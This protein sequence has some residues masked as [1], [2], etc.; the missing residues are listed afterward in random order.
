[1][2][3]IAV[4]VVGSN[5]VGGMLSSGAQQSAA[6]TAANAQTQSAQ[7]GIQEQQRQFNQIQAML[8]PFV[9]AATGVAPGGVS[10]PGASPSMGVPGAGATGQTYDQIRASLLPQYTTTDYSNPQWSNGEVQTFQGYGQKVDEAG[11]NAAI[12]QVMQQQGQSQPGAPGS[13]AGGASGG[14]QIGGSLGAQMALAGVNGP[15]AQQAMVDQIKSMPAFQSQLTLG[16]NRILQNAAATGGL[17]GGNT[18]AA[19]AYFAPSLLAQQINNQYAMLGGLTSIGQNAAAMVGNAG[20]TT[21]QNIAGLYGQQ[22]SAAAGAAIAGGNA[23]TKLYNSLNGALGQYIG[24]GGGFGGGV[25]P[26]AIQG[27]F[28]QT[29]VGSAGFGTGFAYGNQ[30]YGQYF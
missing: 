4:A 10:A 3:W 25:T 24:G 20:M 15:A 21:G 12:Q 6:N 7:L 16:E 11:L 29:G 22:G 28:S 26:G 30:D 5:L 19:L 23:Q 8:A 27:A 14:G 18:Q 13:S 2:S 1:M 9:Q 17:R